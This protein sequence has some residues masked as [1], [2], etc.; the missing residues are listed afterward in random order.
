V[1]SF[2]VVIV[3]RV[4]DVD[5]VKRVAVALIVD[6]DDIRVDDDTDCAQRDTVKRNDNSQ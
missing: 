2:A 6:C 5:N 3:G 4:V 1:T